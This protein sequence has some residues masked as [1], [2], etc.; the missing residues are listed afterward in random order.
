MTARGPREHLKSIP[1]LVPAVGASRS[2]RHALARRRRRLEFW[3]SGR[4]LRRRRIAAYLA[5][6]AEPKLHLGSGAN[7]H[8]G[9]LNTDITDFRGSNEIV[10]LDARETFPLP[11]ESFVLVYSEHM[12]EHLTRDHGM[13]CL[14]ECYRVLRPGG[15]IRV[16]TPSLECL[17]RLY[18]A[19]LSDLEQRYL[20]WSID[21]WVKG[22]A[23]L[24]GLVINNMFHNFEHRFV[25]DAGTLAHA[26]RSAGF[27]D[28]EECAVG[29]STD[30]RLRGLERHMR[31]VAD[32]NAF[33]TIV[34]EA[35][36]PPRSGRI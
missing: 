1:G 15:R 2:V 36:R 3:V 4:L 7:L 13:R 35:V 34:I 12:L 16:A 32:F 24:P 11:D 28:V 21:T 31:T 25:Y 33:E 5:S 6:H 14:R 22:D 18:G 19:E 27:V 8:V 17:I 26:L 29:A 23:Y 9:W 30:P 10:Y 20:R